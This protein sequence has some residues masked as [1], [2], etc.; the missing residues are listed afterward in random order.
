VPSLLFFVL[1]A[2]S[3]LLELIAAIAVFVVY[4]FIASLF[5]LFVFAAIVAGGGRFAA[6]CS[7][8]IVACRYLQ[9]L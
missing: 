3:L 5:V 7:V 9:L 1:I 4:S 8:A 6:I 2:V